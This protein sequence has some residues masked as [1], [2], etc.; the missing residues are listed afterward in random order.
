M[1]KDLIIVGIQGSGKGTQAAILA[2]EF[3]GA[4]LGTG[5]IFRELANMDTPLAKEVREVISAGKLVTDELVYKL[6]KEKYRQLREEY[7]MVIFDGFPRNLAQI[8]MFKELLEEQGRSFEV[9]LLELSKET[10]FER[11]ASRAQKEGRPDDAK[12]ESV[13]KRIETFFEETAPVIDQFTK[14]GRVKKV[15]G[16]QGIAQVTADILELVKTNA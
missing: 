10:A 3:H 9:V 6:V 11:I 7:D 15:D 2:K 14:E 13:A 16:E 4:I 1:N 5:D 8:D 12:E